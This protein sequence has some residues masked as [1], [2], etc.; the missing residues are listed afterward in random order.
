M[1]FWSGGH[2]IYILISIADRRDIEQGRNRGGS[3][4]GLN[5]HAVWSAG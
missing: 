5:W 1:Y 3:Y 2:L 4:T